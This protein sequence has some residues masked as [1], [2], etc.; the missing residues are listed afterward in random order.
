MGADAVEVILEEGV[1]VK[2][3]RTEERYI[4]EVRI[5]AQ[6][7]AHPNI[8]QVL[9]C[10]VEPGITWRVYMPRHR[11]DLMTALMQEY[12]VSEYSCAQDITGALRHCH[13]ATLVHRDVKPE[14]VLIGSGYEAILCDFARA[15]FA[16]FHMM[17]PFE[18]TPAYA[19]P[20]ALEGHCCMANDM[21]SLGVTL[22]CLFDKQFPF[23]NAPNVYGKSAQPDLYEEEN[24]C[25]PIAQA[26]RSS[27]PGLLA[28]DPNQRLRI[29]NFQP[30]LLSCG[31]QHQPCVPQC[32]ASSA[33]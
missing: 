28:L 27:M 7:T 8:I 20:E 5:L 2:V 3:Y 24:W 17:L 1:A 25:M 15:R 23:E 33:I 22:F 21:W 12:T 11:Y 29:H 9:G 16:P 18:G 14:N 6:L 4:D 31:N 32:C 30:H 13:T 10:A 19:A 26:V